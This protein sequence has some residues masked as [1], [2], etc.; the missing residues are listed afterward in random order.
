M[1]DV[2]ILSQKEAEEVKAGRTTTARPKDVSNQSAFEIGNQ[3]F[4]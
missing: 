3:I 4:A 1:K 2:K